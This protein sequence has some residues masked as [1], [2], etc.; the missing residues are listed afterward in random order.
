[1]Q[2][3]FAERGLHEQIVFVGSG[4]LG[5]PDAA[6]LAFAL[7]CD[8]VNVGREALLAIGC[9]QALRCHTNH[10]PTG[11][12]TQSPWLSRGLD[13]TLK[14]ARMANYV[15]SL[16]KELLALSHACGVRHP[17]EVTGRQLEMIDDRFGTRTIADLFGGRG[18]GLPSSEGRQVSMAVRAIR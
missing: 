12:T 2:H 3:A 16:R 8:L 17:S 6:L 10:C 15:V 7:G 18:R 11:I 9:I 1:V 13:P 5:F 14:S 4:K